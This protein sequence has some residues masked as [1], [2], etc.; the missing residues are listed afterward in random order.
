MCHGFGLTERDD[1]FCVNFDHFQMGRYQRG[2]H[3]GA[4]SLKKGEE[5][6][7]FPFAIFCP[8][9]SYTIFKQ[10]FNIS[11][12]QNKNYFK[13]SSFLTKVINF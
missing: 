12:A 7:K 11:A 6:S 2:V 13:K 8:I 5:S 3:F 10:F 9:F 4:A 1:Y